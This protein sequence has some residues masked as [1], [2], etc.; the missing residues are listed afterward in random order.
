M[1]APQ[2]VNVTETPE[3]KKVELATGASVVLFPAGPETYKTDLSEVSR[4]LSGNQKLVE[5][6][7]QIKGSRVLGWKIVFTDSSELLV[8]PASDSANRC[9]DNINIKYTRLSSTL[10]ERVLDLLTKR[11]SA[12]TCQMTGWVKG[13]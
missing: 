10:R 13:N 1:A 9:W 3:G 12:K 11:N 2:F 8:L 4:Q 5:C 7:T 6:V